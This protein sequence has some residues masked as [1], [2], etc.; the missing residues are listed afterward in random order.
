MSTDL[1]LTLPEVSKRMNI[2]YVCREISP[3]TGGGIGTYIANVLKVMQKVGH[4][5]TLVTD[6][7]GSPPEDPNLL[8][9][10]V[11]FVEPI[12]YNAEKLADFMSEH[13]AYSSRVYDTLLE[14]SRSE[15][16][17]VVE[18]PEFRGEGFIS[19]RA[20]QTLNQFQN[21]KLIVKCHTPF[22]L[23]RDINEEYFLQPRHELDIFMEDYSVENADMVTSPSR[24][25][26]RYFEQ[27]VGRNNIQICPYPLELAWEVSPFEKGCI[28]PRL[29]RYFG[30]IQPR[31][32]LD[33][34]VDAAVLALQKGLAFEFE[35]IGGERNESVLWTRYSDL[36]KRRIP[37]QY[38]DDI[39][40]AGAV[41]AEDIPQMMRETGV[42]L[43]PSRWENWANVCLEAMSAGCIVVASKEGGMSEMIEDGISGY[44][45]DPANPRETVDTLQHIIQLPDSELKSISQAAHQRA[46][47]LCNPER[48]RSAIEA[49][50]LRD[51]ADLDT[52]P[53]FNSENVP[54]VSVIVPFYNQTA[55][56]RETIDSITCS[57]YPNIEII[58]INDGSDSDQALSVLAELESEG[59]RCI[60][61]ENC[62]LS[63]AR[64]RGFEA[65]KGEFILP[66]DSDDTI[67]PEYIRKAVK[68]LLVRPDITYVG[69][70]AQNF[71]AFEGVY[72]PIGFVKPLMAFQNTDIKCSG[73]F[74]KSATL[75]CSYDPVLYSYED[76]DF[77]V[78]IHE[79]GG[80]GEVIPEPLFNYRRS[81]QSMVFS[82]ANHQ[83]AHLLQ[84]MLRKHESFWSQNYPEMSR[85]LL[86]LWKE[87]E[88]DREFNNVEIV[89]IYYGVEGCFSEKHSSILAIPRGEWRNVRFRLP[90]VGNVTKLRIDP[91]ANPGRIY[92][93]KVKIE[94]I[95]DRAVILECSSSESFAGALV[96]GTASGE[97]RDGRLQI[98]S[99]GNDPQVLL[100][101][102]ETGFGLCDL[103]IHL[104]IDPVEEG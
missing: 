70:Y 18:F 7:M 23:I 83:K 22:S 98:L 37:E 13:Q 40:F 10:G 28:N 45:L 39:K 101:G 52:A 12:T 100:E 75:N 85:M 29:V 4:R 3:F 25:L 88:F 68:L 66:L 63:F 90:A 36:L 78:C 74:R 97:W 99:T 20:K 11:R 19:I 86:R 30:S 82:T 1:N 81:H 41:S 87:E 38:Q 59:I 93:A 56:I 6:F 54:L 46:L 53:E 94:R 67:H 72:S 64:N 5:V 69:C 35:I 34:F 76:W 14:L 33:H 55:T 73:V 2:V 95:G 65:S 89:Q 17:D 16:I 57:D 8:F 50:Y 31:K 21:T 96:T 26:R 42:V 15:V 47:S 32:G 48:T 104:C 49:N 102:F 103:S 77:L 61:Q 24:S 43:L 51:L 79:Q 58:V 44:Y 27:R 92:I 62:G 9:P 71:G 84:Y 80:K 91:S 60:H